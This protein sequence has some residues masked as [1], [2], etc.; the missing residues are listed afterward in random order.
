MFCVLRVRT[1]LTMGEIC[2]KARVLFLH[3]TQVDS[4]VTELEK[5]IDIA[6]LTSITAKEAV[7]LLQQAADGMQSLIKDSLTSLCSAALK[8]VFYD[9]DI[10][11]GVSFTP[12]KNTTILEMYIEEGGVR[13]DPLESRGHGIA[14]LICF[15]LRVSI[16]CLQPNLRKVIIL[17]EPFKQISEE[18]RDRAIEFVKKVSEQTGIQIILVT[19]IAELARNADKVFK[20][21]NESGNSIVR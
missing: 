9:K 7:V 17:D 2:N 1:V 21:S 4:Q 18:Y 12:Q 5:S 11:F 13:Y 15:A 14:D 16:L 19:H 6:D 20:V 10:T 3:S 8:D